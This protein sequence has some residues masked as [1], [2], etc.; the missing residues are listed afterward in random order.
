M[1]RHVKAAC[2][3]GVLCHPRAAGGLQFGSQAGDIAGGIET[4]ARQWRGDGGDW[5]GR[6]GDFARHVAGGEGAVLHR[7]QRLACLAIEHEQQAVLGD[8]RHRRAGA[9]AGQGEVEQQRRGLQIIV[10]DI[11]AHHLEVPAIGPGARINRHQR[12]AIEVVARP[13]AAIAVKR[14]RAERDEGQAARLVHGDET[15]GVDPA[16]PLG[17][18][19]CP[20]V[21]PRLARAGDGVEG[22]HQRAGARVPG[23]DVARCALRRE[24]LHRRSGDD[25]V[26]EHHRRAGHAITAGA[27]PV[28]DLGRAQ[29][30]PPAFAET[31]RRRPGG[32][33]ERIEVPA[34]RAE[35]DA[36]GRRG[37]ARPVFHAA[38]ARLA[39]RRDRGGPQFH[40]RRRIE[41]HRAAIGRGQEHSPARHQRR[42]L[43]SLKAAG[44]GTE[45]T[46]RF[47]HLLRLRGGVRRARR[48]GGGLHVIAPRGQQLRDIARG[49]LGERG[50]ALAAAIMAIG[51]PVVIARQRRL[52]RGW[53]R[54][55]GTGRQQQAKS[56]NRESRQHCH[57]RCCVMN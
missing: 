33:I 14:G 17:A 34:A 22:P 31:L 18:A 20:A 28:E 2:H 10:P 48:S 13:V 1:D 47:G 55:Y 50:M 41:R 44:R 29:I 43:R 38:Q 56:Q 26:F 32:G 45:R 6:G 57:P 9:A 15:P 37:I 40:A 46:R 39:R 49:D 51:R 4:G 21:M 25:E 35:E 16:A 53:W 12:G 7:Q 19:R 24:F 36:R 54:G 42:H 52:R 27:A 8:D 5:L 11:V 23:A 30:D 3:H